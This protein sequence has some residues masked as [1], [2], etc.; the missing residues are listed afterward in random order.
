MSPTRRPNLSCAP[1]TAS[2]SI[3]MSCAWPPIW[4]S[5]NCSGRA[6]PIDEQMADYLKYEEIVDEDMSLDDI[7]RFVEHHIKAEECFD[8]YT[9]LRRAA[10]ESAGKR[11]SKSK[12]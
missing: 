6:I 2:S 3:S 10:Q 12:A 7:Q 4:K 9:A 11:K 1:S 8:F 5:R